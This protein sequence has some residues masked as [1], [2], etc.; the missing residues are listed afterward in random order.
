MKKLFYCEAAAFAAALVLSSCQ[1]D[2]IEQAEKARTMTISA[3]TELPDM[4]R[5]SI[6]E[7]GHQVIWA[8][9][10]EIAIFGSDNLSA[11]SIFTLSSGAGETSGEF[12]GE[13]VSGDE[14]IAV[15]PASY[16][17]EGASVSKTGDIY[18]I[19]VTIPETQAYAEASFPDDSFL[20][21]AKGT[22]EG[23]EFKN[24][25]GVLKLQLYGTSARKISEIQ[26]AAAEPL[27][28]D[29]VIKYDGAGEPTLEFTGNVKKVVSVTVNPA[30]TLSTDANNP[31]VIYLAVPAGALKGGM[32]VSLTNSNIRS[33]IRTTKDNTI[34]RSKIKA[35]PVTS[36]SFSVDVN[37]LANTFIVNPEGSINVYPFRPDG[38]LIGHVKSTSF[39]QKFYSAVSGQSA[40]GT[41]TAYTN[42]CK[43]VASANEGDVV[44][45]AS[46]ADGVVWS[47]TVW[48]TDTPADVTL[49]DGSVI[50]DRNLGA[51]ASD[52]TNVTATAT[53]TRGLYY[54]WGRKDPC[55]NATTN[56]VETSAEV[57]TVAYAIA[58]PTQFIRPSSNGG[59]EGDWLWEADNTLWGATKTIYDPCPAGYQVSCGGTGTTSI[60]TANDFQANAGTYDSTN[61]GYYFSVTNADPIWFTSAAY[62]LYDAASASVKFYAGGYYWNYNSVDMTSGAK[63]GRLFKMTSSAVSNSSNLKRSAGCSI[64]CMKIK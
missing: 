36:T 12:T 38:K 2:N 1:N 6:G 57:G 32:S 18:S 43:F 8:E 19:P 9:G 45:I 20:A 56:S 51:T 37:K 23:I 11:H 44:L 42:Y 21:V 4:T 35:M 28:G 10:N 16:L 24:L 13:A 14:L 52:I 27:A 15:Y 63:Y 46:D 29:A 49:K 30:F 64:R 60:W 22:E 62:Y 41:I 17:A 33:F 34:S 59:N 40:K 5:T 3:A 50:M 48:I 53:E 55:F 58:N 61:T 47:W 7:D 31:S 39:T 25:M 26:L 54:Q